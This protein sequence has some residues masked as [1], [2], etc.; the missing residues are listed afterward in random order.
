MANSPFDE[1]RVPRAAPTFNRIGW[2]P[3]RPLGP[4]NST[5]DKLIV[6]IAR[7]HSEIARL[8]DA[9]TTLPLTV[10]SVPRSIQ[11]TYDC[12]RTLNVTRSERDVCITKLLDEMHDSEFEA[13]K[14]KLEAQ[15]ALDDHVAGCQVFTEML[16]IWQPDVWFL[17]SKKLPKAAVG[18]DGDDAGT[19]HVR[20][21]SRQYVRL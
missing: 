5:P 19:T 8:H 14:L 4:S 3:S 12:A 6:R 7:A 2:L 17:A 9:Q 18:W 21:H 1:K 20:Q 10:L 16:K 13:A 15:I 11:Y